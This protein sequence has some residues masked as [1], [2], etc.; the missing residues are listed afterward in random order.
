MNKDILKSLLK[1]HKK[2][3]WNIFLSRLEYKK[4]WLSEWQMRKE[5]RELRK[6]GLNLVWKV[7]CWEPKFA[8]LYK[9]SDDLMSYI[10][11]QLKWLKESF[12]I[13]KFNL[14]TPV[15]RV[16]QW[17]WLKW[18]SKNLIISKD[19]DYKYT[20]NIDL[21]I[22]AKWSKKN[23]HDYKHFNLF[24]WLKELFWMNTYELIKDLW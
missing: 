2:H 21:K 13:V 11:E 1:R 15:E 20:F 9:I 4:F 8:N 16:K 10:K 18:Y 23:K 22:I 14:N 7:F 19:D 17:L 12:D 3:N 24:N 5:I 6:I